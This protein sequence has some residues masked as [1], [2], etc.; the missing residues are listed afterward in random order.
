MNFAL[1]LVHDRIA[2]VADVATEWKIY[3]TASATWQ[4]L[5]LSAYYPSSYPSV[6]QARRVGVV[7]CNGMSRLLIRLCA[8]REIEVVW[9]YMGDPEEV[10]E[11]WMKGVRPKA[12]CGCRRRRRGSSTGR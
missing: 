10:V 4:D 6:F 2:P 12:G 8:V 3:R 1:P 11:R 5:D 7:L 9:G